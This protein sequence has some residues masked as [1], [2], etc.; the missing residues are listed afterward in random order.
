MPL[1]FIHCNIDFHLFYKFIVVRIVCNALQSLVCFHPSISSSSSHIL[2]LWHFVDCGFR[3]SYYVITLQ[4][5]VNKIKFKLL[6][7]VD[8]ETNSIYIA[9]SL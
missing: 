2:V 5:S 3:Q 4:T 7:D 1:Q 8:V 6:M 9:K